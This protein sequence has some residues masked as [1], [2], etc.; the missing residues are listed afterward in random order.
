VGDAPRVN[1]SDVSDDD[2]PQF[3]GP[4]RNATVDGVGLLRDWEMHPPRPLWRQPIGTGWSSF[5]IVGGYAVTQEQRD[6]KE[7]V[8]CYEVESGRLCWVHADETSFYHPMGGDGPRATPTISEGRVYTLGATGRLNCLD[9]ATGT[10]AWSVDIVQDNQAKNNEWGKSGSPLVVDDLV[11]VSA[12]GEDGRSLVAYHRDTGERVW[13]G[14]N[15]RS[16]YASPMLATLAGVPQILILNKG[17]VTAHDPSDG[18]LLWEQPWGKNINVAQPV[19][20]DGDKVFVSTGYGIGGALFQLA[21]SESGEFEITQRW[22]TRSIKAKFTNVVVRDGFLY[23]LDD[24]IFVCVDLATGKRRWKAGRYGH[25]QVLGL[26]D[27]LLV[28]AESGEVVLVEASPEAHREHGR[29]Q[30]LSSKTW[31]NPA[32]WRG[33]LLVRNDQEAACYRLASRFDNEQTVAVGTRK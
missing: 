26:D 29:F 30:A 25:G 8:T 31:N 5:A 2:Y 32:F 10:P 21:R 20:L 11:V 17:A 13:V 9:G 27:L 28:Q 18:R 7:L 3:L 19:P 14:G 23:G 4:H 24:G 16:G 12:G 15:R 22:R 1:L 33:Y 6:D